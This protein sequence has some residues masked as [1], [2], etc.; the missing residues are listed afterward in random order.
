[1]ERSLSFIIP[2]YNE[3]ES[4][5]ELY[6]QI[7]EACAVNRYSDYEVVFIDDGSTDRSAEIIQSLIADHPDANITLIR[8]RTNFG[9]AAA[10]QAG[11]EHAEGDVAITMDADLQD[12]PHE[13]PK[14][15]AEMDNGYDMVSGWKKVRHD[16]LEKRL[17]SKL[18]N[19][20]TAKMSGWKIGKKKSKDTGGMIN[21]E[22][23]NQ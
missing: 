16:P 7:T 1:M 20:V 12:D 15:L 19:A 22:L 13:F 21:L 14:L 3:E 2:V 9:K 4:V 10:L 5:L 17:P 11:F 23:I 6:S 8:F 18:F